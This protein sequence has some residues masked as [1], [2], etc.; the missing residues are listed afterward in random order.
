MIKF[1]LALFLVAL[2]CLIAA[3][4]LNELSW[5]S[6]ANLITQ[7]GDAVLLISFALLLWVLLKIITKASVT[8]IAD[9]FSR[10]QRVQRQFLYHLI[11]NDNLQRLFTSQKKQLAYV[12]A[13]KRNRL[14]ARDNAKQ[15]RLLAKILAAQ[16][17]QQKAQLSPAVYQ[18][19]QQQIKHA[20]RQRAV[21]DLL[22]LQNQLNAQSR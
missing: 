1:A 11:K 5:D 21:A 2:V 4:V 12:N 13:L 9:Y 14:F 15:C 17:T 3:D 7:L 19:Y 22:T 18:H 10:K 20:M 16:L 6:L 8:Q